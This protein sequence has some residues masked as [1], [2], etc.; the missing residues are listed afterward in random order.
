MSLS[1][2]MSQ[3]NLNSDNLSVQSF[4]SSKKKARFQATKLNQK[5][6]FCQHNDL[7]D[8]DSFSEE[9]EEYQ[10]EQPRIAQPMVVDNEEDFDEKNIKLKFNFET[11]SSF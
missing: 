4:G 5:S 1:S 11:R 2:A 10:E 7:D 6:K 3:S 8:E 9:D